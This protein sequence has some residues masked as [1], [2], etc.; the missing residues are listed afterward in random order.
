VR[1]WNPIQI[2]IYYNSALETFIPLVPRFVYDP[3][4]LAE[5]HWIALAEP[6]VE[7]RRDFVKYGHR[8]FWEYEVD[9][10]VSTFP[11]DVDVVCEPSDVRGTS[12]RFCVTRDGRYIGLMDMQSQSLGMTNPDVL[13]LFDRAANTVTASDAAKNWISIEN[14][15]VANLS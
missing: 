3:I 10:T 14:F 6:V 8:A 4:V 12:P 5:G 1:I 13:Y 11:F 7:F 15:A 9:L 2:G